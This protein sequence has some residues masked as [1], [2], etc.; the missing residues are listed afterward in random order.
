M[1]D[2]PTTTPLDQPALPE[3]EKIN[4]AIREVIA[5]RGVFSP[6]THTQLLLALYDK[7]RTTQT[8]LPNAALATDTIDDEIRLVTVVF[9][10][11]VESTQITEAI[12]FENWRMLI[13]EAHRR[14]A[15]TI[16]RWGGE[17]GQYLGD[18]LLCFFGARR[19]RGNDAA[20]AVSCALALQEQAAEY[21]FHV[22]EAYQVE[23]FYVRIGISTGRVVVGTIGTEDKSETLAMGSTT[24]LASRLQSICPPGGV[25]VD[26]ETQL[27][28]RSVFNFAPQ[29]PAKL[30]GFTQV[31]PY[32][33]VLG[34]QQH[35]STYL[36]S[37]R[38]G[39]ITIPFIGRQSII[40]RLLEQMQAVQ[41]ETAFRML[42][43]YGEI[44]IGKSRLLQQLATHPTTQSFFVVRMVG[45]YERHETPFSLLRD[46]I[47]ALCNLSD[48]LTTRAVEER[49]TQYTAEHWESP[50][51]EAA[52]AV[53]GYMAGYGFTDSAFIQ[54]L[55]R[56]ASATNDNR[57]YRWV[58]RWIRGMANDRPLIILVDNL[59]WADP[60]SLQLLRYLGEN[61]TGLMILAAARPEFQTQAMPYLGT[62][63]H[64][65][66]TLQPLSEQHT[67]QLIDAVL[68]YVDNV[69]DDLVD[70]IIT[71]AEGNPLF[72]EEFLRM[73][74][75]NGVFQAQSSGDRWHVNTI[76]YHTMEDH[77]PNGLLDVFQ[78]RLDDLPPTERRVV[79]IAAVIGQTFWDAAVSSIIDKDAAA[80]LDDLVTR[81]II[82]QRAESRFDGTREYQFR[83]SL[84]H[85]V[86]YT[87]LPRAFRVSNHQ[88][89]T[90]WL[91]SITE[92]Y[93][94]ALGLL[95]YHHSQAEHPLEA[96]RSYL[97]AASYQYE[98]AQM[99]E[100]IN[101]IENGLKLGGELT[102]EQALP[103]ASRLWLLKGQVAYTRRRYSEAMADSKTAL[104]LM[105]ELSPGTL[106]SERVKA[107]VTLGNTYTSMGHYENALEAL[108]ASYQLVDDVNDPVEQAAVLRAFGQLFWARGNLHEAELYQRR[109]LSSAE[110]SQDDR[111]IAAAGSMLGLILIDVGKF[112]QA[113]PLLERVYQ[114][115]KN[116]NAILPQIGDLRL[117]ATFYRFTFAY[118]LAQ[119]AVNQAQDLSQHIKFNSP[120]LQMTQ[121]LVSIGLG[122]VDKGLV[123]LRASM[124]TDYHNTHD[125][126][127]VHLSFLRGLAQAK[128]ADEC[129]TEGETFIGS[130]QQYTPV[131]YGRGLLWIGM[132][133]YQLGQ[134]QAVKTLR[135]ALD[136]EITYGGRDTWMC[137]YA[138][139][140]AT[141]NR[142]EALHHRQQARRILQQQAEALA[143][144][145]HF[146]NLL[147]DPALADAIFA[148]WQA[149]SGEIDA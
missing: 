82:T 2:D 60:D 54:S 16:N 107:S 116:N 87:M 100:T 109:A 96:V 61:E 19:S 13:G 122:E 72:V 113:L 103:Y 130:V 97:A 99:S 84:Y 83:N 123:L 35:T 119:Q 24:N 44:G 117:L 65:D 21:Y 48:A 110:Q 118:Q 126:Y 66:I 146:A 4:R 80:Y 41:R 59:Q 124:T 47:A 53:L 143:Y 144:R 86:A 128:R 79:Q 148:G 104:M 14:F 10:D 136:N 141:P 12:G 6:E 46:M 73:L 102:R 140:L 90:R 95:A 56:S 75:D 3:V 77:L 1:N 38:I 11:V 106:I 67:R 74:F 81:G 91:T 127:N 29:Q 88:Q 63:Q 142:T 22:Q 137:H 98:Q 78:A 20:R 85:D 50:N 68:S 94:E 89:V 23:S 32:F 7:R 145:P 121:G 76:Q 131:L 18:G 57:R 37:S 149:A 147:S 101:L 112:A 111:E 135:W 40:E 34:E 132:A 133:Q 27:R 92:T 25:A 17:V 45:H 49:I 69:P 71:R 125:R 64:D 39:S 51:A 62:I 108:T 36:T 9:I 115:N 33:L 28:A 129:L 138:I 8:S 114:I 15:D 70:L 93:P 31:V 134:P 105:N 30:K 139:S 120:L 52:A 58:V 42:M 26:S 55:N 43:I 5:K